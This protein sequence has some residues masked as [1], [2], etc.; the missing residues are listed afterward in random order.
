MGEWQIAAPDPGAS[1][2][3]HSSPWYMSD[4]S[5]TSQAVAQTAAGGPYCSAGDAV[6]TDKNLERG[7]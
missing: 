5:R 7:P 1:A 3:H 4:P 2:L 6:V